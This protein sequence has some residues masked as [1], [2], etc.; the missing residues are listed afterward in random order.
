MMYGT[1]NFQLLD[2]VLWDSQSMDAGKLKEVLLQH[3]IRYLGPAVEY[4]NIRRTGSTWLPHLID[5]ADVPLIREIC[6]PRQKRPDSIPNTSPNAMPVEVTT[7]PRTIAEFSDVLWIAF[8]KRLQT[9]AE[10]GG[11]SRRVAQG[12]TGAVD[13]L[14]SNVFEHSENVDTGLAGYRWDS[15]EFEVVVADCGIGIHAS[16]RQHADYASV[17]DAGIALQIALADGESRFGRRSG[18]GHGFR[19]LF[20]SLS[21]LG[22]ALRFRTGGYRLEIVGESPSLS[23]ARLSHAVPYQGFLLSVMT[24]WQHRP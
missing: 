11:F 12:I 14:V 22:A 3:P 13:E 4:N 7:T 21:G 2:D 19:Q 15:N 17:D 1:M 6:E 8:R 18:R 23:T 5:M 20:L 24:N 16:L 9:A 10:F